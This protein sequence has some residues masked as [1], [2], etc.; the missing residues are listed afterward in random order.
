M[1]KELVILEAEA[2]GETDRNDEPTELMRELS[3]MRERLAGMGSRARL[4]KAMANGKHKAKSE[5][6]EADSQRL[7]AGAVDVEPGTRAE[8]ARANE[9]TSSHGVVDI[10]RRI[11]QL[12]KVIGSSGTSLDEV[13]T[14]S[15]V[16]GMFC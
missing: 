9:T 1:K 15:R 3:D 4:I 16:L 13:C 10:D 8:I 11:A 5:G 12:E 7:N 14:L 6:T 2:A